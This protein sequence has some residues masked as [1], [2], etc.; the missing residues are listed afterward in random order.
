VIGTRAVRELPLNGRNFAQL[1]YLNPG[2]T[3]GQ[4][5]ENLSG[6]STFNPRGPS[7]F[8]ALGSRANTNAWLVDGI[9]NNEFTFN[10][11]VVAPSVESVREFKTL[12][13][14]F[15]AEFGRG[16]GVVSIST[17][18]GSNDFHGNVFEFH[19][20]HVLDARNVFAPANQRKPVFRQN[21]FGVAIGGPVIIPKLYNGKNKTFFFFD[22]AG[23]RTG[24]GIATVNSVPTAPMRNGDFSQLIAAGGPNLTIFD[25]RTTRSVAGSNTPVRDPYPGNIMPPSAINPVGRNVLS[26]YPLPGPRQWTVRQLHLRAEPDRAGQRLHRPDRPGGV[27]EGQHLLPLH[28][29]RLRPPGP[30]GPG[31]LLSSHPGRRRLPLHAWTV[32][33]RSPGHHPHHPGRGLQLDPHLQAEPA[34]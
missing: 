19:R 12:T 7:N 3:P 34:P 28:L 14:V 15:S 9:D 25:P 17:Q 24:R 11:V 20:N 4:A 1:V 33:R 30:P 32:R 10:T 18:S 29:Q 6:A 31:Q 5:G 2:V 23:L 21:Q 13:G 16:A 8:N 22:Y 27:F 26:I